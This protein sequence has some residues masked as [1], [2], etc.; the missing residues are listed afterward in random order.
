[1]F[2]IK[3]NSPQETIRWGKLFAGSLRIGDVVLLEGALGGG[4]TTFV[5]GVLEGFG[6]R[7]RVLSPSFTLA[8]EYRLKAMTV[9]HLDL[10]RLRAAEIGNSELEEYLYPG[11]AITLVEWGGK[12]KSLLDTFIKVEFLF[13]AEN[14]RCL[15]FYIPSQVSSRFNRPA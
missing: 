14:K 2:T 6:Y 15:K 7:R 1:M 10:F 12:A 4:K 3:T 11:K 13:L 9:Y 5:R 8:R